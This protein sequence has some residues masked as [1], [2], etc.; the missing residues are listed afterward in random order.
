MLVVISIH[1]TQM[2]RSSAPSQRSL[3]IGGTAGNKDGDGSEN[4]S[5]ADSIMYKR[6]AASVSVTKDL[7]DS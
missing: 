2:R 1:V 6:N 5:A 3:I 4:R 7:R